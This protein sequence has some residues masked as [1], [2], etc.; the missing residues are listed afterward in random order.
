MVKVNQRTSHGIG[1]LFSYTFGKAM[2]CSLPQTITYSCADTYSLSS[3]NVKH[4]AVGSFI[5]DLPGSDLKVNGLLKAIIGGWQLTGIA[6]GATGVPFHVT[7]NTGVNNGAPSW[8]NQIGS[9]KLAHRSIHQ[10]FN[11]ADFVAP[12]PN[13]YG[14]VRAYPL[15]GPGS[16]SIDTSLVKQ[17]TIHENMALQLRLQAYN[18][19]N[20]P[21]FALPNAAIGSPSAGVISNTANNLIT[22]AGDSRNIEGG[23]RFVF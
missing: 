12:P 5:W 1:F 19:L 16:F 2:D 18:L 11:V 8:P 15:F 7:L 23:I 21:F 13:T 22:N 6:A 3:Y 10:W 17:T 14:S 20:H 4:R 9:G